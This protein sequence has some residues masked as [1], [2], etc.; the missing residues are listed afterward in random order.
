MLSLFTGRYC[1]NY[2]KA[3]FDIISLPYIQMCNMKVCEDILHFILYCPYLDGACQFT[4]LIGLNNP[5]CPTYNMFLWAFQLWPCTKLIKLLLYLLSQFDARTIKY[6]NDFAANIIK[7]FQDF[8]CSIHRQQNLY[9]GE[10]IWT[11]MGSPHITLQAWI[12][13][14]DPHIWIYLFCMCPYWEFP[15]WVMTSREGA[16][17]D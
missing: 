16:I 15:L 7:Y 13:I 6:H 10:I 14:L 1:L 11:W 4:L 8:L 2:L 5:N 3:K 17:P 9:F 12:L